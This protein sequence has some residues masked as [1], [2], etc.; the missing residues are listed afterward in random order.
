MEKGVEDDER[1]EQRRGRKSRKEREEGMGN[2]IHASP[3][4]DHL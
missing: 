3:Q 2:G 4:F 1:E